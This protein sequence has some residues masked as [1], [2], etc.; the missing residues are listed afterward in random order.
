MNP[1][2]RIGMVAVLVAGAT[3]LAST[4]AAARSKNTY[5][6]EL[7]NVCDSGDQDADATGQA[8]YGEWTWVLS[9]PHDFE[10]WW[11]RRVDVN[12]QNLTPGATYW[13]PVGTFTANSKGNGKVSGYLRSDFRFPGIGMVVY[14]V[15]ADASWT[16]VLE[17]SS[18]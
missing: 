4:A 16:L 18:W 12:S 17:Y 11:E 9:R 6:Y 15:N 5:T 8:T 7:V 1:M 2:T 14:R 10:G 13:T 3:L